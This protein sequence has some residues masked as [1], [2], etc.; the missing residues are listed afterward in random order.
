MKLNKRVRQTFQGADHL[1]NGKLFVTAALH[2]TVVQ[3]L[4]LCSFTI[5]HSL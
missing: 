2:V 4:L 5:K 3:N 1:S